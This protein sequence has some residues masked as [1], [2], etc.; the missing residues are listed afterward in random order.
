MTPSP[1]GNTIPRVKIWPALL[2]PLLL[3]GCGARTELYAPP[4]PQ[5]PA[6]YCKGAEALSVYL[7]TEQANLYSFDPPSQAFT[8]IGGVSCPTGANPFS[9]AVDHKGT[10]YVVY[11]DG[12]LFEVSTATAA[13]TA[14]PYASSPS[15]SR[16][17]GM[18]FSTDPD[19]KGETLYLAGEQSPGELASLD[20]TTFA[21]TGVGAFSLD[22]GNA[23]LTGT[24]AGKLFGFGVVTDLDGAHL[25]EIDKTDAKIITDTVVPT[26]TNPT[27]WAFAAWGGDFYFFTSAGGAT[28]TVARVKTSDSSFDPS[29]ATL[30]GEAITGAGVST[31]APR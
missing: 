25:A 21:V 17:F 15:F 29:Y 3:T 30:P 1:S 5:L 18:G 26:P 6:S 2:A 9:M 16:T 12:E 22:I 11:G 14:T 19:G 4:I 7:V 28:S 27:S 31:C 24:G 8:L 20:T 23:E 10:A 13:C